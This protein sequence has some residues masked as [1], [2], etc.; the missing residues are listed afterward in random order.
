MISRVNKNHLGLYFRGTATQRLRTQT[1]KRSR[2]DNNVA[3]NRFLD[4]VPKFFV[5]ASRIFEIDTGAVPEC[6]VIRG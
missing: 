3:R 4:E 2:G 1:C 5:T 6:R